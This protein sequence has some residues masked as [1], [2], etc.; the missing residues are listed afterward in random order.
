LTEML[1]ENYKEVGINASLKVLEGSLRGERENANELHARVRWH[2]FPELWWGALWDANPYSW[3]HTWNTWLNS[4]GESGDEPPQEVKDFMDL[5]NKSIVVDGEAR[6]QA[7]AAWKKMMY[8]N[9]YVIVTVE[10]VKYPMIVNKKLRNIPTA[11]FA[12]AANF[13]MEQVYYEA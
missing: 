12:I 7:I 4:N 9:V 10:H 3:G 8:D 5:V 13:A 6:E 2:H 1:A 11:G